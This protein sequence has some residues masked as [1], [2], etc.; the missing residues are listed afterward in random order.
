MS[1]MEIPSYVLGAA[2]QEC[3][4]PVL[5]DG[6]TIGRIYRW[7]GAWF[8]IPAGKTDEIRVGAGSTGSVAAAQFLAQEFGAGRITPQQHTDSSA[9]PRAFVGPVPLLHPRMPATPRNIEGAHKAMTG[10]TEFHWT[11]L[12]GY[13]GADNPW[14]LR[15]QL[16]GWEGP[17]YWSHLRGRN[18]NPPSTF[19]HPE[20]LDAEKVRA[21]ITAYGK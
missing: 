2:D 6:Q 7:H 15:C 16:C 19:R 1:T 3:R 14:F 5:V 10:L 21:A 18:G 12:G 8:A 11:P 4:Y 9:K 13:P 20:C 17:R